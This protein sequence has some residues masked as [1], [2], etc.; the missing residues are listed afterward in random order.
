MKRDEFLRRVMVCTGRE[1]MAEAER[2]TVQVLGLLTDAIP[3]DEVRDMASQLP[4]ELKKHLLQELSQAGPVQAVDSAA[5]VSRV[6]SDLGLGT[7]G[8]ADC[9]AKGVL[10]VLRD[11][12]SP[13]AMEEVERQLPEEFREVMLID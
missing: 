4:K 1:D 8:E 13:G 11:A 12:V 2:A 9:V 5:F 6:Q 7:R 3:R 10:S